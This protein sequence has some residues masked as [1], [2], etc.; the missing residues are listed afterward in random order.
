M[1]TEKNPRLVPHEVMIIVESPSVLI[2]PL[3]AL[4]YNFSIFRL[5]T[6]LQLQYIF[7]DLNATAIPVFFNT[8][9]W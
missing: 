7:R 8:R 9:V 4:I 6:N 3:H 5:T 1:V 2:W